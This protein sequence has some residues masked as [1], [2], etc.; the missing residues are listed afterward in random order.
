MIA[1]VMMTTMYRSE[2]A[3]P[4]RMRLVVLL[5]LGFF[6]AA[7]EKYDLVCKKSQASFKGNKC[8]AWGGCWMDM[9]RLVSN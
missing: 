2:I 6:I 4:D 9:L 7:A 5:V 1:V 3:C 8:M